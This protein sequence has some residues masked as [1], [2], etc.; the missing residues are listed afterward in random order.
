MFNLDQNTIIIVLSGL[1]L[2]VIIL[3]FY[4]STKLIKIIAENK[5]ETNDDFN[6]Q[7]QANVVLGIKAFNAELDELE[8]KAKEEK[9]KQGGKK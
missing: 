3:Q 8:Q 9:N 5:P 1:L 7:M 2:L 4:Q 6:K